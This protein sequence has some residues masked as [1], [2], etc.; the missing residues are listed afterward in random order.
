MIFALLLA[1][2]PAGAPT[3]PGAAEVEA[4]AQRAEDA[5]A[6]GLWATA[7]NLRLEHGDTAAAA[8]D[9]DRSLA[10]QSLSNRDRGEVL[11]DRARAAQAAGDLAM[12]DARSA[13]A[14]RLV[15][16]DPFVWY[17]RTVVAVARSDVPRAKIAI[18]RA[19]A[20]APQD[21]TIL[22]ESGHVAQLGGEEA[23]AR[24]A[25]NRVVALDPAGRTGQAARA[26]LALAGTPITVQS[27]GKP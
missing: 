15:P 16:Q 8:A 7:G 14:A 21:P 4:Q 2:A 6:G 13:E 24:A 20:L 25:W 19:L 5:R 3:P 27:A 12:A 22:F 17:F 1:L 10:T 9:F 23:A 26:A 11:L 18:A